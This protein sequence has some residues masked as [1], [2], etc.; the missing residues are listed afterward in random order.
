M[1]RKRH[2]S[3]VFA[4]TRPTS[5]ASKNIEPDALCGGAAGA[6]AGTGPS[7][8]LPAVKIPTH[9][10][11]KQAACAY[12]GFMQSFDG[13]AAKSFAYSTGVMAA[14]IPFTGGADSPFAVLA[15]A[16]FSGASLLF[17]GGAYAY[18]YAAMM[19]GC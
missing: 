11:P 14:S 7:I 5:L 19:A 15:V 3:R 6:G 12:L 1:S 10:S 4:F 13:S 9:L 8:N 2:P 18:G 17:Q 16:L